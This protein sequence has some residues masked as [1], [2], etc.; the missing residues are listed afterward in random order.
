MLTN[1]VVEQ[2]RFEKD[3]IYVGSV[4][5]AYPNKITAIAL[6]L[7]SNDKIT[8]KQI[9]SLIEHIK[10]TGR[11]ELMFYRVRLGKD[12]KKRYQLQ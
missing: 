4:T 10:A 3:G 2:F 5:L 7:I 12:I 9:K 1:Q 11:T 8:I 6:G